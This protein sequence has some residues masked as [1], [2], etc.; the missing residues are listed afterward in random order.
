MGTVI[1]SIY[2]WLSST[3]L[4]GALLDIVCGAVLA[5]LALA[6]IPGVGMFVS[7]LRNMLYRFFGRTL[8]PKA[9]FAIMNYLTFPGVMAHELSHALVARVTGCRINEVKLFRPSGDALGYVRFTCQGK[10]SRMAFQAAASSCAPVFMGFVTISLLSALA[11]RFSGYWHVGLLAYHAAFSTACHMTMSRQD[12]KSYRKGV[13]RLLLY[14][15]VAGFV[16]SYLCG[17]Q[18][19]LGQ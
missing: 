19:M 1:R 14:L 18:I 9:A 8:G 13:P 11:A 2:G 5:V 10:P 3:G 15:T 12:L 6:A 16:A 17:R 7:Y 4:S